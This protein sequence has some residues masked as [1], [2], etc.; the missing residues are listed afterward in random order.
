M[1]PECGSFTPK[2]TSSDPSTPRK[3]KIL[4]RTL[5]TLSP[6]GKSSCASGYVE[7]DLAQGGAELLAA[8]LVVMMDGE[9]SAGAHP[10]SHN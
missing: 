7:G 2:P 5:I 6:Q 4:P 8:L 10:L 9:G 1:S 3:R